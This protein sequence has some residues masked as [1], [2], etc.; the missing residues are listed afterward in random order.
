MYA[1]I[2]STQIGA[3][4]FHDAKGAYMPTPSV[5]MRHP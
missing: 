4:T 5:G 2:L 3:G 1:P